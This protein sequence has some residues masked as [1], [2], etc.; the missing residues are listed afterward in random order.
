M[1]RVDMLGWLEMTEVYGGWMG[2]RCFVLKGENHAMMTE[3]RVVRTWRNK[4]A[5]MRRLWC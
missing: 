4:E 2:R 5:W 1:L 3:L